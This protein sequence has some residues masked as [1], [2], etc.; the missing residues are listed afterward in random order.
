[1]EGGKKKAS[2]FQTAIGKRGV[3]RPPPDQKRGGGK[4]CFRNLPSCEKEEKREGGKEAHPLRTHLSWGKKKKENAAPT[5]WEGGKKKTDHRQNAVP[6][7]GGHF[8]IPEVRERI[9]ASIPRELIRR[10][11]R[12]KKEGKGRGGKGRDRR[13]PKEKRRTGRHCL[14]SGA[15]ERKEGRK[16]DGC[17]ANRKYKKGPTVVQG[18]KK[19]N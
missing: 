14:E 19:T 5:L 2:S 11:Q 1:L 15:M 3:N 17:G 8:G 16:K 13:R 9:E 4:P 12:G 7:K 18:E 10:R 6:R